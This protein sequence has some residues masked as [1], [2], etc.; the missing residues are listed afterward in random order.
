MP[1]WRSNDSKS[2]NE[3]NNNDSKWNNNDS[4][5]NNEWND[6]NIIIS[7]KL[8]VWRINTIN[9]ITNS[10]LTSKQPELII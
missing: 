9:L 7:S 2:S 6:N 8:Q 1:S 4:K 10:K 3:W 5:W